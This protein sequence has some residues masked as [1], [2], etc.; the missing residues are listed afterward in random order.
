MGNALH[1]S[2]TS[3][4]THQQLDQVGAR[5]IDVGVNTSGVEVRSQRDGAEMVESDED[6]V[7]ISYSHV[8]VMSLTGTPE[9]VHLP[10][11]NPSTSRYVPE[12]QETIP[13]LD[14][15]IAVP[16][17]L[18]RRI[19]EHARIESDSD[20]RTTTS[21]EESILVMIVMTL[22]MIEDQ[23]EIAGPLKEEGPEVIMED[24]L[25]EDT[26]QI[27]DILGEI[28]Q[29]EVEEPLM[30]EDPLMKEDPLI[31]EDPQEVDNI[32]DTQEDEDHQD[33]KDPLD[34]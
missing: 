29:V 19:S 18:R 6:N 12:S 15:P 3:S 11:L 4:S 27:E 1:D 10:H 26:T 14:G 32:L 13:Q 8:E 33:P 30:V 31:M 28:I 22:L 34:L 23:I 5:L 21:L 20:P 7:Q 16:S 17:R 24:H 2:E 25:K 9:Q